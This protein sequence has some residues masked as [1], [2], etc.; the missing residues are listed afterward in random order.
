MK[1]RAHSVAIGESITELRPASLRSFGRY[2]CCYHPARTGITTLLQSLRSQHI[3]RS[4]SIPSLLHSLRSQH[5]LRSGSVFLRSLIRSVSRFFCARFA[6]RP[7]CAPSSLRL[8]SRLAAV[9]AIAPSSQHARLASR[10]RALR[11]ARPLLSRSYVLACSQKTRKL[12]S[13]SRSEVHTL[14][15]ERVATS[16]PS[17]V[18][19][20]TLR[21]ERVA[22]SAPSSA[23]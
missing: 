15:F 6:L 9:L 19:E 11:F 2:G 21:S 7:F 20:Y 5:I 13:F 23:S 10:L 12:R 18:T 14:R 8:R 1:N 3:L 17:S 4:G 16:A 22:T